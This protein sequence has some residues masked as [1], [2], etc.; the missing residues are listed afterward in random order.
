VSRALVNLYYGNRRKLD[1]IAIG[2]T[3][4]K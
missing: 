2:D 3:S 4:W 1:R